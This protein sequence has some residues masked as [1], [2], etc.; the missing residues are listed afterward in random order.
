MPPSVLFPQQSWV[1]DGSLLHCKRRGLV[2]HSFGVTFSETRFLSLKPGRKRSAA[3]HAVTSPFEVRMPMAIGRRILLDVTRDQSDE[4]VSVNSRKAEPPWLAAAPVP[5]TRRGRN[6][7]DTWPGPCGSRR[8][9]R[10]PQ[11]SARFH[12]FATC[13]ESADR[14]VRADA[15]TALSGSNTKPGRSR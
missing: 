7:L 14:S 15:P 4:Q 9:S 11:N 2:V 12:W 6:F 8:P 10:T 5:A 3:E 1:W 13:R